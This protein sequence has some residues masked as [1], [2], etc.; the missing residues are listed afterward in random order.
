MGLGF[1]CLLIDFDIVYTYQCFLFFL[2]K[3]EIIRLICCCITISMALC[4][5]LFVKEGIN[6]HPD[7]IAVEGHYKNM[8][9]IIRHLN[10]VVPTLNATFPP[11]DGF[12][13][14]RNLFGSNNQANVPCPSVHFL[15]HNMNDS[16]EI[17]YDVEDKKKIVSFKRSPLYYE[18]RCFSENQPCCGQT[19][20]KCKTY[21]GQK[22]FVRLTVV[23]DQVSIVNGTYNITTLA[24]GKYCKCDI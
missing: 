9:S 2:F 11:S 6:E 15:R 20:T 10:A 8:S 17:Q 4:A 18:Q 7:V 21:N 19:T 13:R 12:P 16:Y 14:I 24:V 5:P 1:V 22:T 23:H 3:D